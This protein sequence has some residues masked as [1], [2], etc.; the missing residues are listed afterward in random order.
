MS[1]DATSS[2]G[3]ASSVRFA[4]RFIGNIGAPLRR[5]GS[6]SSDFLDDEEI[7]YS[8]DPLSV[9]A[10]PEPFEDQEK[11]LSTRYG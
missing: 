1:D 4:N 5:L 6:T 9:M 11:L 2:L 7:I 3:S 8:N 10:I